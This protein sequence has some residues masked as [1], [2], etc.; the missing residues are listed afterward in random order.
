MKTI[1][2]T[3]DFTTDTPNFWDGYWE[4]R[5]GLGAAKVDP[6]K[7]SPTLKKYHQILW[8]RELPNG[9]FMKLEPVDSYT[10]LQ[11]KDFRFSSD[12][13]IVELRYQKYRNI[14]NKVDEKL[15]DYKSY[16]E[17]LIR[18]GYTIGGMIIFPQHPGSMNQNR[19]TNVKISDRW[20]LTLECIRRYYQDE[21]SPLYNTIKRDENFFKLFVDF[22]GYVDFFFLQDC[23]N[24]DY[25]KVNIWCGDNSFEKSGLP[26]TV[27][28]YFKFIERE[29]DFLEKRNKRIAEFIL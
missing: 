5:D 16:F 1:D 4:R 13:I 23:V 8:S 29:H 26:E 28:D 17:D 12:A 22:K 18:K 2:T 6:D 9:E 7:F 19:G 14:I 15:G 20:D 24:D 3:F 10:Y 21:D 11:W 27:D 25:S